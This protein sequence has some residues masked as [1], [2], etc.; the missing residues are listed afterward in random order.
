MKSP[1]HI[2]D[3]AAIAM[4]PSDDT[5]RPQPLTLRE[6]E[7]I[8]YA[9]FCLGDNQIKIDSDKMMQ[10]AGFKT[11]ESARTSWNSVRRKLI[12]GR[13]HIGILVGGSERKRATPSTPRKRKSAVA[14]AAFSD[15]D[16]SAPSTPS[17]ATRSEDDSSRGLF[18]GSKK[19][20]NG[21]NVKV[22][23]TPTKGK[24]NWAKVKATNEYNKVAEETPLE[25]WD[26]SS[27]DYT[28][29]AR[30]SAA[31]NKGGFKAT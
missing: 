9:F 2:P 15:N 11:R 8:L 30:A 13:D 16:N 21:A 5:N 28:A 24:R 1:H 6:R 29:T 25:G 22:A 26:D 10:L 27:D 23:T 14:S 19:P 7:L 20:D 31:G 4:R 12:A 17:S 18:T 3:G